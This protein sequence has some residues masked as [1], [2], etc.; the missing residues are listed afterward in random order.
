MLDLGTGSGI[1]AIAARALGAK[2]A[3]AFDFDPACV[4]TARENIAAN[5]IKQIRVAKLDVLKWN[6]ARQWDVIAANLYSEVLIAA[7]P[8]I[9]RALK[10]G[11]ALVLSGILRVQE[12]DCVSAF[13]KPSRHLHIEQIIRRGKWVTILARKR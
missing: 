5:R 3:D 7:A 10:S 8:K 2:R 12:N 11:G 9:S 6:P 1:L 13:K 4:R